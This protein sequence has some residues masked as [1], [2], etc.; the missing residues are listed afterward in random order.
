MC[1]KG[2]LHFFGNMSCWH[3]HRGLPG[4]HFQLR[5]I[6][7][8]CGWPSPSQDHDHQWVYALVDTVQE[9][10]LLGIRL[11]HNVSG[12]LI[13]QM[14]LVLTI[15][16]FKGIVFLIFFPSSSLWCARWSRHTISDNLWFH[17]PSCFCIP[18]NIFSV[19]GLAVWREEEGGRGRKGGRGR[20]EKWCKDWGRT[21]R[22]REGWSDSLFVYWSMISEHLHCL[23]STP[24]VH[25]TEPY[26]SVGSLLS[27]SGQ[28][29]IPSVSVLAGEYR[30]TRHC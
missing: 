17:W 12:Y 22:K 29:S 16:C 30:H 4:L 7:V 28:T 25:D 20:E 9:C 24:M 26:N 3:H 21:W 6:L 10:V 8:G 13:S 14:E 23:Q 1:S 18:I 5:S 15:I 19:A 27:I 11:W 2:N